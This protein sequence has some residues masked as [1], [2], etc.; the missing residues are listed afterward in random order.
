[1]FFTE[2]LSS[3]FSAP[4]RMLLIL[5]LLFILI[6]VVIILVPEILIAFIASI[7]L[8]VGIYILLLAWEVRRHEKTLFHSRYRI[9]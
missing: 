9:F 8:L 7:F 4:W 1:M 3:H 2:W 6:G 5:G